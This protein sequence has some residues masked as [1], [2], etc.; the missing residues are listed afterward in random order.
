MESPFL[1]FFCMIPFFR[2]KENPQDYYLEDFI[3]DPCENRTRDSAVKGRCLDLLTTG[4]DRE[5]K[6]SE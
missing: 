5:M 1:R 2:Q 3:G 6:W 4:P